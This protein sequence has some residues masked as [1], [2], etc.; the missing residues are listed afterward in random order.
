MKTVKAK[1]YSYEAKCPYCNTIT[2]SELQEWDDF[3][4]DE[5]HKKVVCEDCNDEFLIEMP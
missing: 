3:I 2:Y 5:D 1:V 4:D